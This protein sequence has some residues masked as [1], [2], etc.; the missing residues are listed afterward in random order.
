MVY[1]WESGDAWL[2][3]CMVSVGQVF[4]ISEVMFTPHMHVQPVTFLQ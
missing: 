3:S 4:W 2:S 1:V